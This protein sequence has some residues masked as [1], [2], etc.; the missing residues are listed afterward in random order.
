MWSL[1]RWMHKI[2]RFLKNYFKEFL[3][4]FGGSS[5]GGGHLC[6]PGRR[7]RTGRNDGRRTRKGLRETADKRPSSAA[8]TMSLKQGEFRREYLILI[9]LLRKQCKRSLSEAR[10][11]HQQAGPAYNKQA[12]VVALVTSCI[13]RGGCA[14]HRET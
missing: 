5:N 14:R 6:R 11:N 2:K 4:S 8:A 1:R 7:D 10:A 9:V 12:R 13:A 3:P